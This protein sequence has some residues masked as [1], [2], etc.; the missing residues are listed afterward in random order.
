MRSD[1][2]RQTDGQKGTFITIFLTPAG[3]EYFDV[4]R[5]VADSWM[6]SWRPYLGG[7]ARDLKQNVVVIIL[8]S[9]CRVVAV[10]VGSSPVL[11]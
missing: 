11:K 6:G 10:T 1:R 5:P 4:L 2:D 7:N 3:T 8:Q 9:K